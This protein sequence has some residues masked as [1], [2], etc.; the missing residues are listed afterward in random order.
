MELRN[1]TKRN[2]NLWL[3][4]SCLNFS[5]ILVGRIQ[6]DKL[7]VVEQKPKIRKT[8][9][10]LIIENELMFQK[11]QTGPSNLRSG[12]AGLYNTTNDSKGFQ[13]PKFILDPSKMKVNSKFDEIP[14]GPGSTH[15]KIIPPKPKAIKPSLKKDL[16]IERPLTDKLTNIAIDTRTMTSYNVERK[17]DKVHKD[18]KEITQ[19]PNF[20]RYQAPQEPKQNPYV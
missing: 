13:K 10:E 4:N 20:S 14:D 11:R 6:L 8:K 9:E 2:Q 15:S 12:S 7:K 3:E 5:Q 16:K 1:S 19:K 18:Q 17:I